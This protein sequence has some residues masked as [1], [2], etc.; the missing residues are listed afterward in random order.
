MACF[1]SRGAIMVHSTQKHIHLPWNG[2]EK[3]KCM[4]TL[5]QIEYMQSPAQT[6]FLLCSVFVCERD[7]SSAGLFVRWLGQVGHFISFSS[8][9]HSPLCINPNYP[10]HLLPHKTKPER[11]ENTKPALYW[12]VYTAVHLLSAAA[13]QDRLYDMQR[14]MK[15]QPQI[16]RR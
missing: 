13:A 14:N 10:L 15:A 5:L 3:V 16:I 9:A 1:S 7:F 8:L 11:C 12:S 4:T 6:M 2:T